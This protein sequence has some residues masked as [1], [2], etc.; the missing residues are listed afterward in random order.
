MA[1][2]YSRWVMTDAFANNSQAAINAGQKIEWVAIKTS[3]DS[4]TF[5]D[6]S[7]F[8]DTTLATATIRQTTNIS[9]VTIT[10]ETV[11]IT[12]LFNSN[13]NTADYYIRTMFLVARYNG[14]EFLAGATVANSSATAFRMPAAS[15]TEITEFTARPQIS[16]SNTSTISATVNPVASATNER[17]DSLEAD[18]QAKIDYLT[19]EKDM[20]WDRFKDFVTKATAETVTGVKTFTQTIVGSITGN[21]GTATKLQNARRINGTLFDGTADINVPAS[22]DSNLV[23]KTGA[24]EVGGVKTFKDIVKVGNGSFNGGGLE[25]SRSIPYID[26][27]FG[28]DAGDYTARIIEN[29]EGILSVLNKTGR[30]RLNADLTGQADNALK[31]AQARNINGVSFDGTKDITINQVTRIAT[32]TDFAT[33]AA[34][35]NTYAGQWRAGATA[36]ANSPVAGL[37]YYIIEVVPDISGTAGIIRVAQYGNASYYYNVVNAGKLT[38][39]HKIA[40]D[41]TVMH[42]F[43]DE[44]V[45]GVKTFNDTSIFN[46]PIRGT[47]DWIYSTEKDLNNITT[48][49][50]YKTDSSF[51]NVPTN[52]PNGSF[53]YVNAFDNNLI[54]QA[55]IARQITDTT[56]KVT[57]WT[58]LRIQ[59]AWGAWQSIAKD[60]D[61]LHLSG[62]E[63][64]AG[65]KKF[66]GNIATTT[67]N[68]MINGGGN[69]GDIA[70]VK[71][72]GYSG[73]LAIGAAQL[74]NKFSIKRSNS[75]SISPSDTFTDLFTVDTNGV[76]KAGT[77]QELVPLDK[78]VIHNAGNEQVAGI[79]TFIQT[80]VGSITGNAGTATKFQ[81]NRKI[82]GVNFD[83]TSDINV[84]AANDANL[85]HK[86][87]AE[88]VGGDKE[89][90]GTTTL[91]NIVSKSS[92][93][94][95]MTVNN[96]IIDFA[97]TAGGVGVYVHSAGRSFLMDSTW[98]E[99]GS[100]PDG[101]TPPPTIVIADSTEPAGIVG[102]TSRTG[103]N[104]KISVQPTGKMGYKLSSLREGD[105]T[106]RT[107]DVSFDAY[108]SWFK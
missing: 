40:R 3:D 17:V 108:T 22:N 98:H 66:S 15:G 26:F 55:I 101:I 99:L 71:K 86:S 87:G 83:G 77:A 9:S 6:L 42:N 68:S 93:K 21:A 80:I 54:F 45:N 107:A 64:A 2:S 88:V 57:I 20:L 67:D 31:L 25:L 61:V 19:G 90:T 5:N 106:A 97:E 94:K 52:L 46:K 85:V 72:N 73:F 59:G 16:V 103:F 48:S 82:N 1:D 18:T 84:N 28:D 91:A 79:K 53:L 76:V 49:G 44:T 96:I 34:N 92:V 30:G 78:N 24:E 56:K 58:R 50:Q 39:W 27:H 100:L 33:V 75:G 63:T 35:M 37:T 62:D 13:N 43:G 65:F 69:N 12:G 102:T 105:T 11:T 47:L 41:E 89:F 4:H 51:T 60:D 81:N 70:F 74:G 29:A 7:G 104:I 10:G 95:S 8:N 38:G 36:I 32:F 23:H 14:K